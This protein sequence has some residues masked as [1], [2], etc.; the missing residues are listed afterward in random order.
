MMRRDVEC[1]L[2]TTDALLR[3]PREF[4]ELGNVLSMT[5]IKKSGYCEMPVSVW[6]KPY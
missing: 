3:I 1:P 5:L 4:Y 2:V 6:R